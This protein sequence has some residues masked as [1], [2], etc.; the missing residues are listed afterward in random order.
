MIRWRALRLRWMVIFLHWIFRWHSF[1]II[2][3]QSET[4]LKMIGETFSG[5]AWLAVWLVEGEVKHAVGLY[6]HHHDF[7]D[8]VPNFSIFLFSILIF[9][10]PIFS[11]WT[12]S[13][14]WMCRN[15]L[16]FLIL[17]SVWIC[18]P[19]LLVNYCSRCFFFFDGFFLR[20]W[21][22]VGLVL[23]YLPHLL[24]SLF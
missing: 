20:L 24:L 2:S 21:S 19:F 14:N 15:L 1:C 7:L 6:F 23:W 17:H 8:G 13:I 5:L 9:A 10:V 3:G 11:V 18:Q 16:V 4:S 22:T 12:A